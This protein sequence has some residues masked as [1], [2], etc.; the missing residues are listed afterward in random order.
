M[1]E[2]TGFL[3]EKAGVKSTVRLMSI[4][5]WW[6]AFLLSVLY[7]YKPFPDGLV[8]IGLFIVGAFAPKLVQ[9][10]AEMKVK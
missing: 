3:E 6:A 8:L 1:S 4:Q 2:K 7:A 5:S 9:K 10:F